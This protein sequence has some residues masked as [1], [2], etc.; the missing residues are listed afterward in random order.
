MQ[1]YTTIIVLIPCGTSISRVSST[2]MRY[3]NITGKIKQF[4]NTVLE[5]MKG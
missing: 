4:Q 5:I 1:V 3:R 2:S